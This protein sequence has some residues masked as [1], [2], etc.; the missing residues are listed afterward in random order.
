MLDLF[1]QVNW[2]VFLPHGIF[3]ALLTFLLTLTGLETDLAILAGAVVYLGLSML[4]Q[5]LVPFH[6]RIGFKLLMEKEYLAAA[7]AFQNSWYFFNKNKWLDEYRSVFMLSATKMSYR[8]MALINRSLCFWQMGDTDK[9]KISYSEVLKYF[10]NSKMAKDAIA[11]IENPDL[12]G[13]DE[14]DNQ[15]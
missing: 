13:D 14:L 7:Q 5:R 1:R 11:Y 12:E 15:E 10:P 8:E 4:L 2:S 9:A 3:V 6:H